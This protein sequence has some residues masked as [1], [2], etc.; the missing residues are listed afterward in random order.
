MRC[1]IGHI[2][3]AQMGLNP[4]LMAAIASMQPPVAR[5]AIVM[6]VFGCLAVFLICLID[7][8]FLQVWNSIAASLVGASVSVQ[9]VL[10]AL[11]G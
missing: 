4:A 7:D 10:P 2:S 11:L 8:W 3:V 9:F 6:C 1:L 5:I